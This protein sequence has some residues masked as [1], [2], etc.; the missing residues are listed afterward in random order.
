MKQLTLSFESGISQK[1]R[2][3]LDCIATGIY[4]KG[5]TNVSGV[6]DMAP[7]NLSTALSG[8]E[9]KYGADE[10][11]RYLDKYGDYDLIYYLI[12]KYLKNKKATNREHLLSKAS[13]LLDDFKTALNEI[14]SDANE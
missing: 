10:I 4:R 9:R 5:L 2:S 13:G 6:V 7:S 3:L 1:H 11:E 12:D 8:G 14:E